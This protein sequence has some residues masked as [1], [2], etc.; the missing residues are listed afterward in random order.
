MAA[1]LKVDQILSSNGSQFDGS[2]LGNVGKVLQVASH[3]QKNQFTIATTAETEIMS[4]SFVAKSS[5]PKVL[6]KVELFYG[7]PD[8][9]NNH[10]VRFFLKKDS[11]Y[12]NAAVGQ[13]N[14]SNTFF[15]SDADYQYNTTNLESSR[16]Q[17]G[18]AYTTAFE[19]FTGVSSGSTITLKVFASSGGT[20]YINR[21]G[22]S[23]NS[24]GAVS[25]LTIMEIGA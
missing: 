7:F 12:L 25:S 4:V 20:N 13:Y 16:Y 6:I 19:T 24:A 14:T 17:F 9:P 15:S 22:A 23:S 8:N 3:I 5:N 21:V 18:R 1:I 11:T 10:E 2:Q